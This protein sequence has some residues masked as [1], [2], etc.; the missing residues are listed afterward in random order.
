M[1][2][3]RKPDVISLLTSRAFTIERV[4]TLGHPISQPDRDI[5][6]SSLTPSIFSEEDQLKVKKRARRLMA[7]SNRQLQILRRL[8]KSPYGCMTKFE[9]LED[10]GAL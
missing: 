5:S 10:V 6:K 2:L 4:A 1:P 3:V 8:A 7:L 9:V